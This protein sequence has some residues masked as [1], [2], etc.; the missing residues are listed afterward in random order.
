MPGHRAQPLP[1]DSID[2]DAYR[3][4]GGYQLYDRLLAGETDGDA[5][6]KALDGT[7]LRGLGGAGFPVGRKW[8]I[9]RDQPAP[10]LCAVNIDEGEPGTFKDRHYM[11]SDPH[12]FLEGM[13]IAC[14]VIGIE[15]CY[16][17]IRDEYPSVIQAEPHR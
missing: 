6:I 11:L 5:I 15:S 4:A 3:G 16:L 7:Q 2:F 12:R 10:R 13:L 8:G 1:D 9:L 14:Q 17:Y